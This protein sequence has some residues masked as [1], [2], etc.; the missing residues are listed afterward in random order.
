MSKISGRTIFNIIVSIASVCGLI[1]Q[2]QIIFKQLMSGKTVIS[3]EIGRQY[4][5]TLPAITICHPQLFSMERMAHFYPDNFT[6]I[7]EL[8]QVELVENG[9]KDAHNLYMAYIE[10][11]TQQLFTESQDIDV[12]F[13]KIS[14][15][16]KS[17]D[18]T[19][20]NKLD[21]IGE[22]SNVPGDMRARISF[23]SHYYAYTGDPLESI[24]VLYEEN[25]ITRLSKCFTFF[26]SIQEQWREYH[27]QFNEIDIYFDWDIV[28]RSFPLYD[29]KWFFVSI[30]SSN[31]LPE[32]NDNLNYKRVNPHTY[33][34]LKYS[35]LGIQRL[36]EG[37]DTDCHSYESDTDFSYYRLRSDCIE[38]CY[39]NKQNCKVTDGF[40]L[41]NSLL[42][43]NYTRNKI[44]RLH[45]CNSEMFIR[46]SLNFRRNCEKN[47]KVEC[48]FK[49]YFVEIESL[50]HPDS[51]YLQILHSVYPD[52]FIEH[53]PS[54]TLMDFICNFAGLL[55]MWLGLSVFSL[56][57][58]MLTMIIRNNNINALV[59]NR[60]TW[61]KITWSRSKISRSRKMCGI[62][63]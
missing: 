39:Q 24:A 1:Y 25:P 11:F 50:K 22:I 20:W 41:S 15:K 10:N 3:V 52:I 21:V 54:M 61:K 17:L 59:K 6:M 49:Y 28:T 12:L 44:P 38:D 9:S 46:D 36:G 18:G 34:A 35:E 8:Y 32:L 51:A 27:A 43:K 55:G 57:N 26:S 42:R 60:L 63:F 45:L 5:Q 7:N 4:N 14:L 58:D 40:V 56:F 53:V 29:N 47:C 33:T 19:Q 2:T 16:I 62:K 30:H 13:D 23:D 37:Y 48:K 31:Y